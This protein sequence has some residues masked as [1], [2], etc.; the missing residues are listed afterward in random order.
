ML[1]GN[2]KHAGSTGALN[3]ATLKHIEIGTAQARPLF[4][5]QSTRPTSKASYWISVLDLLYGK[6][7]QPYV[8]YTVWF[9]VAT[10]LRPL[11]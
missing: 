8:F 10:I 7:N 5:A 6:K 2:A 3:Y 11:K 4:T 9:C 1:S